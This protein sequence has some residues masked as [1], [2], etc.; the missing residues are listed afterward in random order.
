[1]VFLGVA[2]MKIAPVEWAITI[3]LVLGLFEWLVI[4]S[5]WLLR[6]PQWLQQYKERIQQWFKSVDHW[7]CWLPEMMSEWLRSFFS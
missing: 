4:G 2:S 3:W 5:W 6:K 1:M 7:K